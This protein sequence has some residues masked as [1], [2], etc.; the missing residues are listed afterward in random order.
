MKDKNPALFRITIHYP[1]VTFAAFDRQECRAMNSGNVF[2]TLMQGEGGLF[3]PLK[4]LAATDY[5]R[6]MEHILLDFHI[7]PCDYELETIRTVESFHKKTKSIRAAVVVGEAFFG[8]SDTERRR[9]I[10]ERITERLRQIGQVAARQGL[11]TDIVR[12]VADTA[13]ALQQ[14]NPSQ[15]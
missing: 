1:S 10:A 14:A 4:D 12:L 13:S 7:N 6:D 15:V 9:W 8:L 2:R 11:D 5:G 3:N